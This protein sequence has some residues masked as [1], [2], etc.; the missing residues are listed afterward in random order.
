MGKDRD[1]ARMTG[2]NVLVTERRQTTLVLENK[3]LQGALDAHEHEIEALRATL[4]EIR[5]ATDQPCSEPASGYAPTQKRWVGC[6]PKRPPLPGSVE[7]GFPARRPNPT[8]AY[9]ALMRAWPIDAVLPCRA[10]AAPRPTA[11]RVCPP[12]R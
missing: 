12:S 10:L 8:R 4:D 11:Y 6:P 2:Y 7:F 9:D 5:R 3:A 1:R